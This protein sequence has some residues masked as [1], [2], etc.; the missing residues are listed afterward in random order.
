KLGIAYMYGAIICAGIFVFLIAGLFA[1]MKKLF[2]PVVTGSL[3]TI[4]GFTLV[5]VGFQ[6]LGGGSAAAKS[7]G[8]PANLAIGFL[9]IVI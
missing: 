6:N 8:A 2:P 3:I 7:F 9:T 4:I 5:P 1:K